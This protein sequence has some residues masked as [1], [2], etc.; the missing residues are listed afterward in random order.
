MFKVT[1]RNLWSHKR[2]LLSTTISIVLGVAFMAGTFVLTD[3]LDKGFDDL[4]STVN[5]GVDAEVRGPVLFES[6]FGGAQRSR[7]DESVVETVRGV[8]GVDNAAGYVFSF[9]GTVLDKEGD[10]LGGAGPPTILSNFEEDPELN[11][12]QLVEGDAPDRGRRGRARS[13]RD[14]GWRLRDRRRGRHPHPD[15]HDLSARRR[16]GLR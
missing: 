11:A 9:L 1:I 7:F 4:F 2:R 16:H 3:T 10:S 13:G 5:E 6:D 14:R 12:F 8:D 15:P